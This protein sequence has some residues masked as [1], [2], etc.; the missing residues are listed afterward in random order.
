MLE[1]GIGQSEQIKE[2]FGDKVTFISDYNNPPIERVAII[3][4]GE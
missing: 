3:R 1:I 2:L 4:K